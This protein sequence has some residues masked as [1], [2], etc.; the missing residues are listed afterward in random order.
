M[1]TYTNSTPTYLYVCLYI[2]TCI[3]VHI[4]LYTCVHMR[5]DTPIQIHAC[6]FPVPGHCSLRVL[7]YS[8]VVQLDTFRYP[9]GR[10]PSASHQ[11]LLHYFW[12][13]GLRNAIESAA[14][15]GLVPGR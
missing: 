13:G 2:Y 12:P 9:W 6:E 3:H 4:C 11:R 14:R 10:A 7:D 8:S 15:L 5:V 1:H